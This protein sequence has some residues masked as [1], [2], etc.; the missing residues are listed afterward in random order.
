MVADIE[1]L[2][3]M[4][5]SELH[6]KRLNAKESVNAAKKWR[7]TEELAQNKTKQNKTQRL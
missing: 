1:A 7:D 2:E 5:A 4:D 3:E 6:A